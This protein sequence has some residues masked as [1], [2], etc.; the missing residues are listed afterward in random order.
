MRVKARYVGAVLLAAFGML[1]LGGTAD[2]QARKR[3]PR[4]VVPTGEEDA[5]ARGAAAAALE[6]REQ[7]LEQELA[8]MTS[9][10]DK[11][12]RITRRSNG[13]E[14]VDLQGRF[15]SVVVAAPLAGGGHDVSCQSG[16]EAVARA[17]RAPAARP[18]PT[19]PV[20]KTAVLEEK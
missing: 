6:L 7:Q 8:R 17:R 5:P 11:G 9:R 20:S 19:A 13:T 1:A 2:A 16:P 14:T 4:Q 15:M 3:R 12:L 18:A 10:S